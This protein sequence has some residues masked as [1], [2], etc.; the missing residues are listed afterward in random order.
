MYITIEPYQFDRYKDLLARMFANRREAAYASGEDGSDAKRDSYD[1]LLPV[2][3][4]DT[5]LGMANVASSV[6]LLPTTGPT[7]AQQ[8]DMRDGSSAT[9]LRSPTVWEASRL[10]IGEVDTARDRRR[11][12]ARLLLACHRLGIRCGIDALTMVLDTAQLRDCLKAGAKLDTIGAVIGANVQL[13]LVDITAPALRAVRERLAASH[14]VRDVA[15]EPHL[16]P[17]ASAQFVAH[18]SGRIG[19]GRWRSRLGLAR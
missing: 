12:I 7:V 15:P 3:L 19:L 6:R 13:A 10:S 11:Q 17:A 1:D 2:Y 5:D 18:R 8:L 4:V 16:L 9:S 14:P